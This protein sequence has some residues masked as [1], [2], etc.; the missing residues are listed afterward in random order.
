MRALPVAMRR[1][2]CSRA[3]FSD[4]RPRCLGSRTAVTATKPRPC[5]GGSGTAAGLAEALRHEAHLGVAGE[6]RGLEHA[7]HDQ[8]G[9]ALV[10]LEDGHAR[11]GLAR[12]DLLPE[13]ALA[14]QNV[15]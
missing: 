3:S 11:E 10:D 4:G 15:E 8:R 9:H 14:L 6:C 7:L 1:R 13:L 5:R 12:I 2:R